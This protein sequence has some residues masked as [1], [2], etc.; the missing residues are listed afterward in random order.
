VDA[1]APDIRSDLTGGTARLSHSVASAINTGE[2]KSSA[3]LI[4]VFFLISGGI[5]VLI[6]S[7][8]RKKKRDLLAMREPIDA[9]RTNVLSGIEYLDGYMDVLPKN[10][11]DSDQVRIF[12]QSASQKF[13]QAARIVDR[14]TEASDL[15]RAQGLFDR[16]Q[17][18]VQQARRY[19]DRATGGTGNIPGDD[20]MRPQPIPA[21]Q[22]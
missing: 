12:R 9:L 10:N 3:V 7:A 1:A 6:I 2:F 14:A 20:A 21:G 22:D 13:E 5:T 8:Y 15:M 19:L 11:P 4:V 17:A 18:D 16:A